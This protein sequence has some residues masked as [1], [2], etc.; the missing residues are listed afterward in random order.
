MK[1]PPKKS[2]K[3][4]YQLLHVDGCVEP[5]LVSVVCKVWSSLEKKLIK[6]IAD[7]EYD[8]EDGL[9]YVVL[10]DKGRLINVCAFSGGYMDK[11]REKAEKA[12]T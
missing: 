9:F 10:D 5:S 6:F 12:T 1:K 4:Q 11:I 8:E 3:K 7:G 2:K